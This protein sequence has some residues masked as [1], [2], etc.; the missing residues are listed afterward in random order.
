MQC[1][2][3]K[4]V[5]EILKN[6][7]APLKKQS[8]QRSLEQKPR[9][10]CFLHIYQDSNAMTKHSLFSRKTETCK[11]GVVRKKIYIFSRKYYAEKEKNLVLFP[12]QTCVQNIHK[13]TD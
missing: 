8:S 1:Q 3:A 5:F 11:K 9:S 12:S 6:R 4:R 2:R 7:V 13:N 10:E